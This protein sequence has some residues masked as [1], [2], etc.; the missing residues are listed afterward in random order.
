MFK[1]KPQNVKRYKLII[2]QQRADNDIYTV[3]YSNFKKIKYKYSKR[4]K[5]LTAVM[6]SF[7]SGKEIV[8]YTDVI[9]VSRKMY[10][11]PF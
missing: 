1:K 3:E 10:R 8:E 6:T 11:S 7:D 9:G 5:E 2:K 4:K